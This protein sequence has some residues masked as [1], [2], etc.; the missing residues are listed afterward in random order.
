MRTF[1]PR[2]SQN[3]RVQLHIF[4]LKR[5]KRLKTLLF[6]KWVDEAADRKNFIAI[7]EF[8][9]K[10]KSQPRNQSTKRK[11][12]APKGKSFKSAFITYLM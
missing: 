4:L 9:L 12:K 8:L 1:S 3:S 7:T 6:I 5:R 2:I 11:G 10:G